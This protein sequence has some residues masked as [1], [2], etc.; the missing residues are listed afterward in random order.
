MSDSFPQNILSLPPLNSNVSIAGLSAW[1][2]RHRLLSL[3]S[4]RGWQLPF[5]ASP[6]VT[7]R[8]NYQYSTKPAYNLHC[9]TIFKSFN[10]NK[11]TRTVQCCGLLHCGGLS[12]LVLWVVALLDN[13]K[14]IRMSNRCD[15][16]I[17]S[18]IRLVKHYLDLVF[19]M[20]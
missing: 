11:A 3:A 14:I 7:T 10:A 9:E 6:R 16:F 19:L 12:Q 2:R 1:L 17:L 20:P 5:T 15:C 8:R 18:C 13:D 4:A